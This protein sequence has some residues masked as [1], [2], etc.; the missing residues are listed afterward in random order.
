[1]PSREE[2][3]HLSGRGILSKSK[4]NLCAVGERFGKA[5]YTESLR[6]QPRRTWRSWSVA[7]PCHLLPEGGGWHMGELRSQGRAP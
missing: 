7:G 3:A 2:P 5:I 6:P 4:K 1:M